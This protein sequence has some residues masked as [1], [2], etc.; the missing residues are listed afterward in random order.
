MAWLFL[1]DH[2][3][4]D[5][6]LLLVGPAAAWMHTQAMSYSAR[7]LTD[8]HISEPVARS[9]SPKWKSL[10]IALEAQGIWIRVDGGWNLPDFLRWNKTRA[11]VEAGRRDRAEAG[12]KGGLRSGASR[13]KNEA[14]AE[15]SASAAPSRFASSDVEPQPR[16]QPHELAS[17]HEEQ[18]K[19]SNGLERDPLDHNGALVRVT[20]ALNSLAGYTP[21]PDLEVEFARHDG[22]LVIVEQL[23]AFGDQLATPG[24][25]P[26]TRETQRKRIRGWLSIA[27]AEIDAECERVRERD[28]WLRPALQVEEQ[29][30][31]RNIRGAREKFA[32][33]GL[34]KLSAEERALL[35]A[36]GPLG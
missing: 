7:L 35:A 33:L 12:R 15:A 26:L 22:V 36:V 14:S 27:R 2:F 32:A 20:D 4:E 13:S 17:W 31:Q 34:E 23:S 24:A 19:T 8:G 28:Q 30:R 11:D 29:I 5:P 1:D 18:E 25:E 9:L 21:D 3:G 6:R 10:A 16:T